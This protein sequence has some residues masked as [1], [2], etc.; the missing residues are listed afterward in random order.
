MHHA[1]VSVAIRQSVPPHDSLHVA[2]HS[3]GHSSLR[4]YHPLGRDEAIP[5]VR[6]SE[7]H[8]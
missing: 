6:E 1:Q 8:A 7:P 2:G 5:E 4:D 3:E